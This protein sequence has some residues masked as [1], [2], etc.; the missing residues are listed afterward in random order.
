MMAIALTL[1]RT[2][3]GRQLL[4]ILNNPDH[5]FESS[6]YETLFQ[7]L[8][9]PGV[10]L[11]ILIYVVIIVPLI[12]EAAKTMTVW[13]LLRRGLPPASAFIGGAIGGAAYGLFEALFLT[14]PGPAWTTTMIARIGATIMH[15]FTAGLSSWG[16][17]QVVGNRKWKRF[18]RAY[19][20]AVLMHA[21]WNGIAL[22][23][24]FNSI[25][26]EYQYISLSPSIFVMINFSGVIFLT[27]LSGLA[28][29][30]LI[31]MP[32]RLMR[33]QI[34]SMSDVVR[35]SSYEL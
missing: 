27:L 21:L 6:I 29:I 32:Q 18:G 16:L 19:F 4:G 35:Q 10:L 30:G 24:S 23:I 7:I 11:I 12:E 25:G 33:E 13:P 14:Q 22:G 9:Q 3:A 31:R 5:W 1:L 28:L 20:G 8:D 2:G 15:S 17:T 26:V 34:D